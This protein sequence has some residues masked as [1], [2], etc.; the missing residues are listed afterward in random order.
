MASSM[1]YVFACKV[2][3]GHENGIKFI[4]LHEYLPRLPININLPLGLG[5][6]SEN[7]AR[8]CSGLAETPEVHH[9]LT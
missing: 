4:P 3:T 5:P 7:R 9:T 6:S 8:A 2:A 1:V